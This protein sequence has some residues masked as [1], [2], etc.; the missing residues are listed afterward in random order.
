MS[1]V[2]NNC[3]FCKIIARQISSEIIAENDDVIVI[4][5]IAPKAPIHYLII[6]KKHIVDIQSMQ[7]S[8]TV[9]GSAVF[10]MAQQLSQML[11]APHAF[12]LLCSNG[13]DAGQ[14]VFHL[15]V[16]FLAGKQM[17]DF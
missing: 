8:D 13:F 7:Q 10:A 9:I 4:K 14:R 6:P 17:A 11:P 1:I 16:H 2:D 15:H 12:R 3:I 5:D